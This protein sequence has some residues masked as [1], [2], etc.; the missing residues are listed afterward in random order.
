MI[1]TPFP[2]VF[3]ACVLYPSPLRDLLMHLGLT[4][5]CQPKWSVEIQN[6]WTRNLLINNPQCNPEKLAR[7]VELMN[8]A[9]PDANVTNYQAIIGGLNLP[10]HDDRHVLAVAIKSQSEI[11]VTANL[12]DFPAEI[13]NQYGIEAIHPDEFIVDLLDLN[14]S[15]VY[16]AVNRARTSMSKPSMNV[17]EYLDCLFRQQLPLTVIELEKAKILL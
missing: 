4:D 15:H 3:D 11:I 1:L 10:D 2:V 13:L 5:L 16:K 6:E 14:A 8:T 7:T 12:K 17:D 9:L